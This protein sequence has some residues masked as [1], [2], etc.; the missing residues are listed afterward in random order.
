MRTAICHEIKFYCKYSH[1]NIA[2]ILVNKKSYEACNSK[3]NASAPQVFEG[4][5][6][7]NSEKAHKRGKRIRAEHGAINQPEVHLPGPDAPGHTRIDGAACEHAA[8]IEKDI[9]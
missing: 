4:K 3:Q 5:M 6:R 8:H 9:E 2:M 1:P 7:K